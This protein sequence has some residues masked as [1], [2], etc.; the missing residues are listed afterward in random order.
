MHDVKTLCRMGARRS[1]TRP[2]ASVR[3]RRRRRYHYSSGAWRAAS[4]FT[5]VVIK[6]SLFV[7]LNRQNGI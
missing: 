6:L 5:R 4:P 1:P 2:R 3:Y 7:V